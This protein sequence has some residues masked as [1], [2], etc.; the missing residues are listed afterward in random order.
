[1][2][3][4]KQERSW[5]KIGHEYAKTDKEKKRFASAISLLE[6]QKLPCDMSFMAGYAIK[7]AINN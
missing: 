7:E 3:T 4:K 5:L 2:K 1:M 6:W